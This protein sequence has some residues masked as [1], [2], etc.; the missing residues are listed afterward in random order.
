MISAPRLLE[1]LAGLTA[2]RDLE[3]LEFSLLKTLNG[4]LMPRSIS[5][6]RLNS[7]GRP[8]MEIVYGEDHCSVRY[9]DLHLSREVELADQH[10]SSSEAQQYSV[11]VEQGVVN[12]FVLTATRTG[13]S[14]LQITTSTDLSKL[15]NYL[16]AGVLQIYRNFFGLMQHAQTDQ[17][18]GLANR[19]TFED[20]VAKVHELMPQDEVPVENERRSARAHNYWLVMVDIDHFKDVNDRFGH[21]FGD[22]VLV[23]LAQQMKS[24]FREDDMIFRFGGEEFVMILRCS[25][26]EACHTMLSR[27]REQIEQMHIPQVGVVTVSLGATRMVRETFTGTLVDYADQAMYHSKRNGR[28]RVTFFEDLVATGLASVEEIKSQDISFF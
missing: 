6:M 8:C 1:K 28:N 2:I 11:R 17:L 5:L 23:M 14:Y 13:R 20:C 27:F 12:V 22:E 26:Q 10:L 25:D 15:D 24:S 18:T 21:L 7:L 4:I 19:K 16:M 3:L 9:E